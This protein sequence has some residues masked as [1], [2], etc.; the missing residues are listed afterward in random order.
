MRPYE[1]TTTSEI[2][3]NM[4]ELEL[5]IGELYQT[6]GQ[7]WPEHK[8]FWMDMGQAEFKH[9]DNIDR[10]SKIISERPEDF[11]LGRSFSPI[12]IKTFISGVKSNIQR[13]KEK[14]SS[15]IN[16]L[17]LAHDIEQSYLESK[18]VEIT[19]TEDKEFKSLTSGIYS[20]TVF[21][22]EYLNKKIRELTSN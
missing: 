7:L 15:E 20:D 22:R 3:K 6:C 13:L 14:E 8:E 17:F 1:L 19:K 12:A 4:G 9:A 2:L 18:Y 10:M 16:A 11:E 5:A 21:H